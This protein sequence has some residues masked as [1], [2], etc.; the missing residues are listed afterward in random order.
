MRLITVIVNEN[1]RITAPLSW[2]LE[3]RKILLLLIDWIWRGNLAIP[4]LLFI[5]LKEK[6][7]NPFFGSLGILTRKIYL[8]GKLGVFY[9]FFI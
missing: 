6:T 5:P 9:N 1:A 3:T 7:W 8:S 4:Q 2:R